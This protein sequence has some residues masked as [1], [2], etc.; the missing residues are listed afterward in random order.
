MQA[1][2]ILSLQSTAG[3]QA[4]NA[5]LPHSEETGG[6][7]LTLGLPPVPHGLV[8]QRYV[9]PQG[10]VP[11]M[12][13][14]L[15]TTQ[16]EGAKALI[17]ELFNNGRRDSLRVLRDQITTNDPLN[18]PLK[19]H[20][21]KYLMGSPTDEPMNAES[22]YLDQLA[23]KAKYVFSDTSDPGIRDGLRMWVSGDPTRGLGWNIICQH[24]RGL[25]PNDQYKVVGTM[26]YMIEDQRNHTQ[27][28]PGKNDN[29]RIQAARQVLDGAAHT[30]NGS[31][32][33]LP[34]HDDVSYRQSGVASATTYGTMIQ[35][36]DVIRDN[37]FWST[38]ALR[39]RGSAGTW[40]TNGTL[41]APK[42]Y[43]LITG[44][45]GKYI[46]KYAAQEEGQH[47]VLFG[48]GICF[49]VDRI[50]NYGNHTLF[51]S[52]TE[53]PAVGVNAAKNPYDGSPA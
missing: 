7:G 13:A 11:G 26:H 2:N 35:V 39:I 48:N 8:V 46:S 18:K 29:Q 50:A 40:G 9:V 43:F 6:A 20:I 17:D 4:V 19:D 12:T 16:A 33:A 42:V 3:N 5:L 27:D 25:L 53:V 21:D 38:S 41:A 23:L 28:E 52:I 24:L 51:V 44:S 37:A 1:K 45:T 32:A 30:I 49:R 34:S 10:T 36:G 22:G 47:E 14:P 15:D 31:L